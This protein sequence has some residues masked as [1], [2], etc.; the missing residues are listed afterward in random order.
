MGA[1]TAFE[2]AL[3]KLSFLVYCKQ[4]TEYG[5]EIGS[6]LCLIFSESF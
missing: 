5:H 2:P 6:S 3:S 4:C 1:K